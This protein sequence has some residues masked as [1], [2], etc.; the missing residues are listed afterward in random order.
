MS[1]AKYAPRASGPEDDKEPR[2]SCVVPPLR[3]RP[4][5]LDELVEATGKVSVHGGAGD[6]FHVFVAETHRGNSNRC[7]F[8]VVADGSLAGQH[9]NRC[10]A[11]RGPKPVH[12]ATARFPL[13]LPTDAMPGCSSAPK[14]VAPSLD[15][16]TKVRQ[17]KFKVPGFIVSVEDT[18]DRF[19]MDGSTGPHSAQ[20]SSW[21]VRQRAPTKP[22]SCNF[23]S[24][25]WV[26]SHRSPPIESC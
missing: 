18:N 24:S 3:F 21:I 11:G 10:G 22:S 8:F 4:R 15:L 9:A 12:A 6:S 25:R 19:T 5:F 7:T 13:D 16:P 14:G 26:Y 23:N 2:R 17:R 1:D 20:F